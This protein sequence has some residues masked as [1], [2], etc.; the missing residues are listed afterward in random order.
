MENTRK[1]GR[2]YALRLLT[3]KDRTTAELVDKLRKKGFDEDVIS[4][5]TAEM[6]DL[7]YVDDK[8]YAMH[9][10]EL[11]ATYD[12][13]GPYRIRVE[14]RKRGIPRDMAEDAVESIFPEGREEANALELANEWIARRGTDDGEKTARRLYGYLARRGFAPNVVRD[15]LSK[16]LK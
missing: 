16:V 8:K 5:I 4:S 12:K 15:T 10:A 6:R 1:H 9:F 13:F 3:I 2:Q 7:G 14:L 11:R